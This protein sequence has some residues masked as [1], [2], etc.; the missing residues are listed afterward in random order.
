LKVEGVKERRTGG[1]EDLKVE[2]V[3]DWRTGGLED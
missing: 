1:L 2:G 3:K